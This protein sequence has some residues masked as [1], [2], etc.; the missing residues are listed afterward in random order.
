[1]ADA[2]IPHTIAEGWQAF[3]QQLPKLD[4]RAMVHLRDAYVAG[5]ATCFDMLT[6]GPQLDESDEVAEAYLAWLPSSTPTA[7]ETP[8]ARVSIEGLQQ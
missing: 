6:R 1:M 4:A 3:A 8:L 2:R 7:A 5:A